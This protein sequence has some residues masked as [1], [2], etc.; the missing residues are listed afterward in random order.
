MRNSDVQVLHGF[1]S[2]ES[3]NAYLGSELFKNDVARE[4]SPFFE[5]DP[6]VRIYAVA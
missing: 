1:D 3:A 2:V 4:L 6:D 5:K